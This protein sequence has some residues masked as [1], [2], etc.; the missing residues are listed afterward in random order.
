[1]KIEYDPEADA[2]YIMLRAGEI[3][4]TRE[5]IERI[6]IDLDADGQPLGIEVLDASLVVGAESL[7]SVTLSNLLAEPAS[8]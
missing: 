3:A 7:G 4:S 6:A 5:V 1:M 2:L 8:A